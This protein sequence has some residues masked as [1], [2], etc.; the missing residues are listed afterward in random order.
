MLAYLASGVFFILAL[1]GLSEPR[2]ESRAAT[3]TA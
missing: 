1:R 3:A 2:H